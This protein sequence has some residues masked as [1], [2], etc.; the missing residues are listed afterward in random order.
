MGTNYY[1]I[2]KSINK[3]DTDIEKQ[4]KLIDKES[5]IN[6]IEQEIK[7]SYATIIEILKSNNLDYQ[8]N[9]FDATLDDIISN[10]EADLNYSLD[11]D[12][13]LQNDY[14]KHIGK[15]SSGWLFCFQDQDEWHTYKEFKKF[16]TSKNFKTKYD[17]INEYNEIISVD[18]MLDIIDTKQKDKRNLDNPDNFT[19]NENREGY[20]FSKGDFS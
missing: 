16:I 13:D 17:I 1:I 12:L 11:Y 19:H 18:K 4:L 14:E 15:S 9:R 7:H 6:K 3:L 2:D 20:R 8:L 10:L 5:L